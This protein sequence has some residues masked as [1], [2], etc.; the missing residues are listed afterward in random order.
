MRQIIIDFGRLDV[1]GGVSLRIYGYGLMMVL[2][3][4]A[5]IA[6]GRRRARRMGEN[7][8]VMTQIGI[9]SLIGGV[10]GARLAYVIQ[11]W[12]TQFAGAHS[13]GNILN[14][15]SG[16]L[17]YYGG[18]IL[19]AVV[20]LVYLKLK[21]LPIRR[22]LDM[23]AVSLMVGLAF[24][25]MGCLLNGCCY[26]GPC[27]H[28]WALGTRFPMY[29]KPLLKFDGRENPFS[30]SQDGPSPV[31]HHQLMQRAAARHDAGET[32]GPAALGPDAANNALVSPPPQ[33]VC[34]RA[35]NR[36][37]TGPDGKEGS[38]PMLR[39]HPPHE[40]H[41]PLEGNQLGPVLRTEQDAREAF[42]A[43]AGMDELLDA[44][45]WRRGLA[46]GDGLLAG[47]EHW[48]EALL[49]DMS[50]DGRLD[51]AEYWAYSTER[52]EVLLE[53]FDEDGD[54]ALA[55][56]EAERANAYLQAD[57]IALAEGEYALPVKPAQ[58]LGIVNALLLAGILTVFYRMRRREGQVLALLFVLYPITRFMLEAI[59]DDNPHNLPAGVLTHNQYT[60]LAMVLG[61]VLALVALRAL[62]ASCGPTWAGRLA[63][64]DRPAGR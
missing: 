57:E 51:F 43:L 64:K 28:D 25:R 58:A 53:R 59:R 7:P 56:A 35:A 34:F 60:S 40:L 26:G 30:Q 14:I 19:A 8:D 20:V 42:G 55:G 39:L 61:G 47:C 54:G 45:E 27:G 29:S 17:I 38:I 16:G 50:R 36:A 44:D 2:G 12:D 6:V 1:F 5:A 49:T 63:E 24:G 9:L 11:H 46:A 52:L 10:L 21:R 18:L 15:T 37:V 23:V 13:L 4:L 32:D 41:G 22:H 31:Y 48:R 33:L 62:P 3:F